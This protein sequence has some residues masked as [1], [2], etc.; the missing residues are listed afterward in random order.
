MGIKFSLVAVLTLILVVFFGVK[1][2]HLEYLF[3]VYIP[4]AAMCTFFL[5]FIYRIVY[6]YRFAFRRRAASSSHCRG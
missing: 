6:W 5:G 2:A 4:Y 1:S 3:G